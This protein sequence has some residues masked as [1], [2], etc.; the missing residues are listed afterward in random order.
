MGIG[1]L[2]LNVML[3]DALYPYEELLRNV[4]LKPTRQDEISL[5][6]DKFTE[7]RFRSCH[8]SYRRVHDSTVGTT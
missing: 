3:F 8:L 6:V 5:E 2:L 7:T 1:M 4:N